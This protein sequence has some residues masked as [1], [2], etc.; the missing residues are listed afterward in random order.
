M[1]INGLVDSDSA[2]YVD[3]ALIA[4]ERPDSEGERRTAKQ[5]RADA[6]VEVCRRYLA[7]LESPDGNRATERVTVVADITALYRA[8][9]RGAGVHT[10][11]QLDDFLADR[12]Y[13]GDLERGLFLDAFHG[14]GGT[15]R[16]LEGNPNSDG[17]LSTISSGSTLERFL[18]V[19]G[20][21]IDM[22]RSIRHFTPHQRRAVLARDQGCRTAGCDAG[23]ERCD[24]HH[25][26]P[27]ETGGTSD[28]TNAVAKCRHCHLD[29][30]RKGWPD[31]LERDG[32]YTVTTDTG[33]QLTTRPPS[34]G[35]PRLPISATAHPAN[36]PDYDNIELPEPGHHV[37]PPGQ[38]C[39]CSCPNHP[40]PHEQALR[41]HDR[42]LILQRL[43][44]SK[45]ERGA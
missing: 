12:P 43:Q 4:A 3:K 38:R 39:G 16:T 20:R 40:T 8:A 36:E 21:V 13:L 45:L 26:H 19:E 5:R 32:T 30:H 42:T 24:I 15:A 18:T 31:R 23:P 6:L 2:V 1:S 33:R 10:A 14:G 34:N 35:Q 37:W 27:W 25:V 11:R 7:L 28:L 29:H 17:L 41:D 9:L 22:G 44:D